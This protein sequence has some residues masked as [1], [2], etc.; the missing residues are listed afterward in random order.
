MIRRHITYANVTAT[1]ALVLAAGTGAVYAAGEIGLAQ[2]DEQL[3]PDAG[4]EGS[5]GV[6]GEDVRRNTLGGAEI[7]EESLVGD[8]IV[9]LAGDAGGELRSTGLRL[10][11]LCCGICRP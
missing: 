9:D 6:T 2:I 4:P 7:D 1:L 10:Q 11:R 5:A 3:G 8:R